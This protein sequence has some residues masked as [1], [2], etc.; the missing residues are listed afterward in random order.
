MPDT[1]RQVPHDFI[2]EILKK[3]D[4]IDIDRIVVTR[5]WGE[6]SQGLGIKL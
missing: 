4:L 1:E 2:R 5:G 6:V 3:I